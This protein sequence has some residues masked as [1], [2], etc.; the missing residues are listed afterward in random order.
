MTEDYASGKHSV[1]AICT[2]YKV[3]SATFYSILHAQAHP[4]KRGPV[5]PDEISAIIAAYQRGAT[6]ASMKRTF[7]R[8]HETISRVLEDAGVNR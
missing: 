8:S 4:L 7:K 5:G 6:M 3:S 1:K 2:A